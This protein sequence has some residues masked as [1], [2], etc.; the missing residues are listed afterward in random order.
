MVWDL[1]CGG[2]FFALSL[3]A[4]AREVWGFEWV[5]EAVRDAR[6]NALV[7]GIANA[8]FVAGDLAQLCDAPEAGAW[9]APDVVIVDPPRAG[10]HPRVALEIERRAPARIVWVACNL[11]TALGDVAHLVQSGYRPSAIQP[12]D[13]F[14]HTPHVECVLTLERAWGVAGP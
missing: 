10:L 3:A 8:R 5:G 11:A 7:N 4:D 14:P 13:L 2:G 9:P 12:V 6:R 1:Y